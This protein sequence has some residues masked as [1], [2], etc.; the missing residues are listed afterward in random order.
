MGDEDKR[1]QG[2]DPAVVKEQERFLR[3]ISYHDS[4]RLE[5]L[6]EEEREQKRRE[7]SER[8]AQAWREGA[9]ANGRFCRI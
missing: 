4:R 1:Y 7:R 6:S 3:T 9:I 5:G 2:N 8:I